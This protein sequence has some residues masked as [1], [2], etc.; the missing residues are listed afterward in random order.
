[1]VIAY[2]VWVL[3][4]NGMPILNSQNFPFFL[5]VNQIASAHVVVNV[6]IAINSGF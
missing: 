5:L 2:L 6:S 1:M 4:A 3:C